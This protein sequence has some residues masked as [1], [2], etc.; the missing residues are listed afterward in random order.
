MI[1]HNLRIWPQRTKK[2]FSEAVIVKA[3][4][5]LNEKIMTGRKIER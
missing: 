2:G 3:K 4:S 1:S 5:D